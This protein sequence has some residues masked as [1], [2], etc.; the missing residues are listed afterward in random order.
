[1]AQ[2]QELVATFSSNNIVGTVTFF[3]DDYSSATRIQFNLN[4]KLRKFTNFA[5]Q[6]NENIVTYE[7]RCADIGNVLYNFQRK[8]SPD[9]NFATT[10]LSVSGGESIVGRTLALYDLDTKQITCASILPIGQSVYARVGISNSKIAGS[11]EFLQGESGETVIVG[12]I[13]KS[14]GSTTKSFGHDWIITDEENCVMHPTIFNPFNKYSRF[15][16]QRYQE[17]CPVGDLASKHGFINVGIAGNEG[18]QVVDINLPVRSIISKTLIIKS[19]TYPN[20]VLGCGKIVLAG[21]LNVQAVFRKKTNEGIFGNLKF[22][23]QSPY[24]P[25]D[26]KANLKGL[27][28]RTNGFHVHQYPIS[29]STNKCSAA[30]VGGHLNPFNIDIKTSPKPGEGMYVASTAKA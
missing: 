29:D 12:E 3:A 15:C 28:K 21:P 26:F 22:K 24:H 8:I 30:S 23:Q 14:D 25:T 4:G 9:L 7:N 13:S 19:N 17:R 6:I 16:S 27:N 2:G 20:R 10:D 5:A 1:M 18:L 11:F